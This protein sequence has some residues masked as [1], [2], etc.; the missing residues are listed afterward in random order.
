MSKLFFVRKW[1]RRGRETTWS[2]T[3]Q[4]I[5]E[6]LYNIINDRDKIK[7]IS[8]EY[9]GL[10]NIRVKIA[11]LV[12]R[13][14]SVDGCDVV[15]RFVES[16]I[17]NNILENDNDGPILVFSELI[18]D[19]QKDTY[20]YID[21]SVDFTYRCQRNEVEFAKYVPFPRMR[22]KTLI[23]RREE[24]ALSFYKKCKGIFT[25][26][27]W[28]ADD[29]INNTSIPA[30]KVYCVGGG[31]NVPINMIDSTHKTGNKFLF[32]G[33]DFE[34]KNGPLVIEAFK[35]LNNKYDGKFELYIAGPKEWPLHEEIPNGVHFLG[36]KTSEDLAY[37]FNLC[38]I[39]VMPSVYEAYG[40][41]FAEALIYGLPIIGRNA[42]SMK[43]FVNNGENGYLL[44]TNNVDELASIMEIAILNRDKCNYV[45]E[46]KEKYL[47]RYSWNSVAD[48]MLSVMRKDGYNI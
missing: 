9:S 28:L 33:K 48:K 37:Y 22:R 14:M 26:G 13:I 44:E 38:D 1:N 31:V 3:P 16:E 25:M 24:I 30:N 47:A 10:N 15:E 45:I 32:V 12:Q 46:N 20:I 42:F 6:A 35:E 11:H 8:I 41:V 19:K 27:Q 36:L 18:T 34:R 29:I 40:I 4:G 7:E 17:V 39:F 5:L 21:C 43:E 2:G 23:G